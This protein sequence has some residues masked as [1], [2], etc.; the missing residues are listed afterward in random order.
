M[1]PP[2]SGLGF[3][4]AD[5]RK[6]LSLATLQPE[7]YSGFDMSRASPILEQV[8][9]RGDV[10]D[11]QALGAINVRKPGAGAGHFLMLMRA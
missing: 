5:V 1:A 10:D 8:I 3:S 11:L 4:Y 9:A 6:Y 7:G 2:P